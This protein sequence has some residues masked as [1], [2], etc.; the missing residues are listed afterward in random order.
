MFHHFEGIVLRA[1]SY[2]ESNQIV[3]AFTKTLGKTT[4]MARGSKKMRSRFGSVTEPFTKAAFVCYGKSG[5]STL[6]QADLIESHQII[7]S[8]LLLTAYGAY[9]IELLDKLTEERD[10]DQ[11]LYRLFVSALKKL[12]EG[13]DAD[14]LTRIIE[15]RMMGR[16]GYE[17]VLRHCVNCHATSTLMFSARQGG[18]LCEHCR[19]LDGSALRISE[20]TARILATLQRINLDQLGTIS[21]K[22]ETKKQLENVL[23]KFIQEYVPTEMRSRKILKQMRLLD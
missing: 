15:L 7:R 2:G 23:E 16:A 12:Q 14:I 20:S 19:S 1:K 13:I 10:P 6:S 8:N 9:W 11:H 18:F 21:V 5:M 22:E 17:P 4:F 3:T